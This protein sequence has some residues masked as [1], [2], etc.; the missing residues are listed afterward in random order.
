VIGRSAIRR[1]Q[2]NAQKIGN[3]SQEA[4]QL[5]KLETCRCEQCVAAI[6]G[7]TLQPTFNLIPDA[8]SLS[9]D[10]DCYTRMTGEP[11]PFVSLVDRDAQRAAAHDLPHIVQRPF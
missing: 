8:S 9:G 6:S 7:A 1:A 5:P 3:A 11:V 10:V 2:K 4:E